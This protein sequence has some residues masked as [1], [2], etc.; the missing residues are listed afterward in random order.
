MRSRSAG[1]RGG[2]L[3][4]W[5]PLFHRDRIGHPPSTGW[6]DLALGEEL[7]DAFPHAEISVGN[8]VK[9]AAT[10]EF[11][12]GHLANCDPGIYLNLGTG[13]AA[14]VVVGGVVL[15]GYHGAS[16][17]IGYNLRSRD[18]VDRPAGRAILEDFVSGTAMSTRGEV[19]LRATRVGGRRVRRGGHRPANGRPRRRFRR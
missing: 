9:A 6:S 4:L 13:L 15:N 5:H 12:F 14:A 8:D 2:R 10:A 16:G 3:H 19:H 11:A 7:Q 18:D 17:E 1:R